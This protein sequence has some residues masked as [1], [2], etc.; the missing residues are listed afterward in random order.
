MAAYTDYLREQKAFGD[1]YS[2]CQKNTGSSFTVFWCLFVVYKGECNYQHEI[3]SHLFISKQTVNSSLKQ[4]EREKFIQMIIPE[5]NQR[6]RKIVLTEK[7]K[8]LAD[9]HFNFLETSERTAW[10]SLTL[11][12][13]E[14]LLSGLL[15]LKEAF[16]KALQIE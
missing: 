8:E 4:L 2:S 11:N 10:N 16:A 13:Q 12:E 15:K 7:G 14:I 5:S 1:L 3:S 6:I 9:K